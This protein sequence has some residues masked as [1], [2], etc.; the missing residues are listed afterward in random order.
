M[1]DGAQ[2][3]NAP[4][5]CGS[6]RLFNCS[7]LLCLC[8]AVNGNFARFF[9]FFFSFKDLILRLTCIAGGNSLAISAYSLSFRSHV[10][11]QAGG[12]G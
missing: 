2:R 6:Y 10:D 11:W 4:S 1:H 12:K 3:R 5:L 8:Q 9:S 7:L